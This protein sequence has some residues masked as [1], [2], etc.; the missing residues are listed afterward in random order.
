MVVQAGSGVPWPRVSVVIPTLNEA[1][2]LPHVFSRLPADLHEVIVVDG[3]SVDD[4]PNT[5]RRLRPDVRMIMQSR[6]GKGNA[7]ACGFAA[8]TGDVIVM[9]DAD[10]SAD[11]REIPRF[12]QALLAGADFALGSRFAAGGGSRDIT[13]LRKLGNRALV[14]LVNV[15]HGTN[16]SDLCYGFNAFWRRHL[17]ALG[18]DAVT[19]PA[20]GDCRLQGDGFEIETLIHLRVAAAGLVTREVPSFEYPRIHGVSN[21]H[22]VSDGLRVLRTI[23]EERHAS[24]DLAAASRHPRPADHGA[25]GAGAREAP[26]TPGRPGAQDRVVVIGSGWRFASGISHYTYRLSCALADEYPVG[27][28]LMRRLLPRRL[29]PGRKRVG[30]QV[31]T[32]AY[33]ARIPVYDGV[34]WYWGRSLARALRYLDQQRPTVVVLEWWSG[35]VLHTY[36]RLARYAAQHGANVILE[37]HEGQ[38]TGEAQVPG[39]HRYVQ[40]LM[41]RL[42][43]DVDAHVVHSDFDL[44]A[45]KAAFT[46]GDAPVRVIP[47]GPYDHLIGPR[48]PREARPAPNGSQAAPGADGSPFRLLYLGVVRPFKGVED[49]VAAFS[50]LD[51]D[52]AVR[53]RL[54]VVGETWE[55]WTAPAEAIARSPHSDLIERVDRYVT[56]AEVAAFFGQADA[57]VLPYHRSSSSGPL[58]IAMSAG[59]PVITTAVGG[60]VEAVERYPGAILVPP[61]NPVALRQ[62]LLRLPARRGQR[63]PDPH[64][65]AH[66][67]A[68]YRALIG[69]LSK[70]RLGSNGVAGDS[71]REL[72]TG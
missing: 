58:H 48:A 45:I 57:V 37:W 56:D 33:P 51:R 28:L 26:V 53:F 4:T 3:H 11:P 38:D 47:H 9:L 32:S 30:A 43:S 17:P 41:P 40:S 14:A 8:A 13:R 2:N 42:L 25:D 36:L 39:A 70:A 18:L 50:G 46:L 29:Y 54:R 66:T 62:A 1:R 55:G 22:A 16:Y 21:L 59:L 34:D 63:Y 44:R 65:W 52:E 60:L 67:T 69:E 10:G 49:L 35:A 61:R 71:L 20:E 19:A 15:R 31:V 72:G 23:V 24:H 12:V 68:E 27:T 7:V 64:S 6:T 5:A